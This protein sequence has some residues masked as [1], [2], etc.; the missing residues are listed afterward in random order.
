MP[1]TFSHPAA[2][3]PLRRFVGPQ[4]LSWL[5]LVI[6]SLSP[7]LPY[8]LGRFQLNA[9]LP[10]GIFGVALPLGFLLLIATRWLR[11]PV[12]RLLPEPHRALALASCD[13]S[14]RLD[15]ASLPWLVLSLLLGAF[16]HVAWDA[17]THA[18]GFMVV[19]VPVLAATLFSIGGQRILVFNVLQHLSTAL[20]LLLL[21]LAYRAHLRRFRVAHPEVVSPPQG[22]LYL[23]LMLLGLVC[24]LAVAPFAIHSS[25]RDGSLVMREL[26]F[27]QVVFSTSAFFVVLVALAL[28]LHRR[29]PR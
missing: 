6:G 7:D 15:F 29:S 18:N 20:G 26:V 4:R 14:A 10:A 21:G 5:A 27:R 9:H 24:F 1:W 12:A 19:R 25:T 22:W 11:R 8:Y 3:L 16:T 2:V 23:R 17:F 28:L 13:A